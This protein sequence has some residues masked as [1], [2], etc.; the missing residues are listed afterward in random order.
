MRTVK[1]GDVSLAVYEQG[2]PANPTVLLVHGYPDNHAMWDG[3]VAHLASRFHVVTY[4][5]RG[6]GA[7]S[8]PRAVADYE[9]SKLAADLFAVVDAVSPDRPVH[10]AAHDWGSVQAWHAVTDDDPRIASYTT[11]SGPSLDHM[12]QWVRRRLAKPTPRNLVQVAKQQLHS[13]YIVA[14]HLPVL[15]ELVWRLGATKL[16]AAVEKLDHVP[17]TEDALHGMKLYRANIFKR[18]RSP[19]KRTTSVPVQLIVPTGDRYLSPDV[20][21]DLADWAPNLWRRK[22][23]GRHWVASAKPAVIAEMV[24]EFVSHVEGATATR[25]LRRALSSS[26]IEHRL[27]LITGAGSG[28]GRETALAF[29]RQ[30]ADVLVT[31]IDLPSAN[32]TAAMIGPAATAYQLDVTDESAMRLLA[33]KIETEHGVPDV[34]VNNAGIAMA[35]PFLEMSA[36]QLQKIVDVNLL[37][38]AYGCQVF[39][40]MM[41]ESG[42]GG[43]IVNVASAA[44]YTPSRSLPAYAATKAAVLSLSE[45]LRA[46]FASS[47][48][49]VSAICPGIV[50]TPITRATTFVGVDASKQDALRTK[51]AKAYRRRNFPP[52]KV[53]TAIVD[54]VRNNTAVVPVAVEAKVGLQ[55]SRFA[56]GIMRRLARIRMDK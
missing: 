11:I 53:A 26:A 16:V 44:A 56:P 46:D 17:S 18:V 42:L 13:W 3:V 14:F 12:G 22:V 21:A 10:V 33:E 39:G 20:Y 45:S 40:A 43:H 30:G 38:V 23:I 15:P 48:I 19:E 8:K 4:D 29:A 7:S 28:I 32:E 6:A 37:G 50:D 1:S 52:S 49:G 54:A 27:V 55:L 51:A 25:G 34:V 36:K 31:D 2:D 24:D 41:V 47:G 5:V 35:G 9:V